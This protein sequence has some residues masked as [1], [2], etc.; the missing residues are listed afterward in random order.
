MIKFELTDK[1]EKSAI[2][3]IKKQEKS[4]KSPTTAIGG[5]FA[6]RFNVNSVAYGVTIID[7][8]LGKEKDITDY[9]CW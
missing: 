5:R 8:L 9:E 3:W 1:E 4:Q 7:T 2:D 6:Y